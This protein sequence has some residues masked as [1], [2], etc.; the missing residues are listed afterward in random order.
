MLSGLSLR[1]HVETVANEADESASDVSS[2]AA[3]SD[4]EVESG[5]DDVAIDD[6]VS[7]KL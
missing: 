4:G 6:D 5:E 2:L 7:S 1:E 3:L